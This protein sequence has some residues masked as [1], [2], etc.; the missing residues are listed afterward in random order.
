MLC[1]TFEFRFRFAL[2]PTQQVSPGEGTSSIAHLGYQHKCI[3]FQPQN[4]LWHKLRVLQ[5]PPSLL[6]NCTKWDR[7]QLWRSSS[8]A[9]VLGDLVKASPCLKTIHWRKPACLF[10]QQ[11]PDVLAS[12]AC[13]GLII[14]L[15]VFPWDSW[16]G[17]GTEKKIYY[18]R[19]LL[20]FA[21]R[22]ESG[23]TEFSFFSYHSCMDNLEQ[24]I[25]IYICWSDTKRQFC[26]ATF[27]S[28][29]R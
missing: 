9:K 20:Q 14:L 11:K 25:V 19:E 26:R 16:L 15:R 21:Y 23:G 5:K 3:G 22:N 13:R 8:T 24:Q 6:A 1:T 27:G 7:L 2:H 12:K 4:P 29:P 28:Y 18:S 10:F 17:L